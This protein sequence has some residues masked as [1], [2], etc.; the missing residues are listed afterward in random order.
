[1]NRSFSPLY[2]LL[3]FCKNEMKSPKEIILCL[4][5]LPISCFL[6]FPSEILV[7]H[8]QYSAQKSFLVFAICTVPSPCPGVLHHKPRLQIIKC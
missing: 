6:L 4:M 2:V 3:N 1:M 7:K 8:F 5:V